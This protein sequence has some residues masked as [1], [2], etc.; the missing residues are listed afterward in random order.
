[1]KII[2]TKYYIPQVDRQ[3]LVLLAQSEKKVPYIPLLTIVVIDLQKPDT[4]TEVGTGLEL[5]D[6]SI[7]DLQCR[8]CYRLTVYGLISRSKYSTWY[9][10]QDQN[11]NNENIQKI[12]ELMKQ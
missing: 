5:V 1:M 6:V 9:Y 7:E 4:K 3:H 8:C 10:K 11:Y 12:T 2:F